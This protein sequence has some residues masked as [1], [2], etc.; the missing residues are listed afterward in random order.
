MT[1]ALHRLRMLRGHSL[2]QLAAD[3]GCSHET[4][5]RLERGQAVDT[6]PSTRRKF[7]TTFGIPFDLL[8]RP[9]NDNGAASHEDD[10]ANT[11]TTAEQSEEV[12]HGS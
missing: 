9:E 2:R 6:H 11:L 12:R 1:T 3:V 7:E 5:R 8:T 10:A 4:V